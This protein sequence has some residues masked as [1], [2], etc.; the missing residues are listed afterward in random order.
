M[1][2]AADV[3]YS[4]D[5]TDALFTTL[6]RLMSHGINKVLYLALEKRY[7]FSLDDL[8]VVANGYSRFRSYVRDEIDEGEYRE[9]QNGT[10]C[11]FVG[12]QIDLTNIPQYSKNY[13]R[14]QDVEL[15]EIRLAKEL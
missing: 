12:T 4:D 3:I 7:N 6:Q 9:L 11:S 8:D 13:D 14:G 15:W 5:L 2:L 10:L 1:L